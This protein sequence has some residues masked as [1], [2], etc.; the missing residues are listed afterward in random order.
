MH[1]VSEPNEDPCLVNF[2]QAWAYVQKS[3]EGATRI[4][5]FI[6]LILK[7]SGDFRE[8][9]DVVSLYSKGCRSVS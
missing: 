9:H 4:S 1:V 6:A 3:K 7:D 2:G 8:C 5:L